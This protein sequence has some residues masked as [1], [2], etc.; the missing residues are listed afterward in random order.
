MMPESARGN[1]AKLYTPSVLAL[2]V[3]LAGYPLGPDLQFTGYAK[4]RTCGSEVHVGLEL[5]DA[6]IIQRIGMKVAACAVGQAS[7]A[8]F[9][10]GAQGLGTEEISEQMNAMEL[11]IMGEELRPR[12][13][14]LGTDRTRTCL[15]RAP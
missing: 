6:G 11:W 10:A 7:A 5:D 15:S 12:G 8:L 9:A 2:S 3:E 4:S 14:P 13:P 1:A